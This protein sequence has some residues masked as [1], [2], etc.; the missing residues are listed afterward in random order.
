MADLNL[1]LG[2]FVVGLFSG[3]FL[4]YKIAQ[5]TRG[6]PRPPIQDPAWSQDVGSGYPA[7]PENNRKRL[8]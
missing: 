4:A 8:K 2:G 1:A 5:H 6:K 7:I 3:I